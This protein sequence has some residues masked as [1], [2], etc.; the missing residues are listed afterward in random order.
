MS[1]DTKN[2]AEKQDLENVAA[3]CGGGINPEQGE[4]PVPDEISDPRDIGS[5]PISPDDQAQ[6]PR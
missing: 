2:K 6:I 1:D 4:I 5:G 3:G